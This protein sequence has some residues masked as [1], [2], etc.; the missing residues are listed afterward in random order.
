[1]Q[2]R[3]V[4]GK[5]GLSGNPGRHDRCQAQLE[6]GQEQGRS[7][8]DR[9][10]ERGWVLMG[11][12]SEEAGKMLWGRGSPVSQALARE[13]GMCVGCWRART[14]PPSWAHPGLSIRPTWPMLAAPDLAESVPPGA[15]ACSLSLG[16]TLA[17]QLLVQ[18]LDPS[19]SSS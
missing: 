3:L 5:P 11:E 6:E 1:M 12:G 9:I 19:G 17:H 2:G 7:L 4:G 18:L 10:S 14:W 15:S 8:E 13:P 16:L